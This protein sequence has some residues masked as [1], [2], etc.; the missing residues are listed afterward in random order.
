MIPTVTIDAR[1]TIAKFS[2]SGIPESV[3]NSLRQVIPDLTKRLGAR[4]EERLN[5]ELKS[6]NRLVVTKE[7]IENPTKIIGR[8]E[9]VATADPKMLP[10]WLETGTKAHQITAA[11]GSALAFFWGKMGKNVMFKSVWHPGF[12]GINYMQNSFR[13]MEDEIFASMTQAVTRGVREAA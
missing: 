1:G 9:T 3:R 11:P 7:M 8:V 13:D 2:P 4:V 5:T 12:A 10:Q 6:R